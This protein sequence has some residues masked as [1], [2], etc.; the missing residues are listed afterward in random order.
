MLPAYALDIVKVIVA[1]V[2]IMCND[3]NFVH[4]FSPW[5]KREPIIMFLPINS[6]SIF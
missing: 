6:S 3:G 2:I 5:V 1:M 4:C